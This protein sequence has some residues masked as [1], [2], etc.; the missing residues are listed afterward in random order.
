MKIPSRRFY[1][2]KKFRKTVIINSASLR[3]INWNKKDYNSQKQNLFESIFDKNNNHNN[4]KMNIRRLNASQPIGRQEKILNENMEDEL[5]KREILKRKR[6][7]SYRARKRIIL[8]IRGE[9]QDKEKENEKN[10]LNDN[11]TNVEKKLKEIEIKYPV[12]K[13]RIK[14]WNSND[15]FKHCENTEQNSYNLNNDNFIINDFSNL[16]ENNNISNLNNNTRKR[17]HYVLNVGKVKV[18]D[19]TKN[20]KNEHK[21]ILTKINLNQQSCKILK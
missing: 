8:R 14:R 1:T 20:I 2:D 16:D 5:K 17:N 13:V 6:E 12:N 19:G 7:I 10:N 9:N 3:N 21:K 11:K 18:Q 15:L 4:D